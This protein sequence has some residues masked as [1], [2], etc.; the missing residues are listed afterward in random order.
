MK[1]LLFVFALVAAFGVAM[2]ISGP[3]TVVVEDTQITVVDDNNPEGKK[4]EAK[5][6]TKSD[7]KADGCSGSKAKADGCSGSKAKADG[8]A[9]SKKT[10]DAKKDCGSSC[11]GSKTAQ[12]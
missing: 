5:A 9:D 7:A 8:C 1:K 6:E 12:K 10:A 3:E 2:A 4:S 11:G